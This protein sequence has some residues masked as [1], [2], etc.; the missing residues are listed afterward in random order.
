ME[1]RGDLKT[2]RLICPANLRGGK[3]KREVLGVG[4]PGGD[5]P[6][7]GNRGNDNRQAIAKIER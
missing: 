3:M 4:V 1:I 7:R 2:N 6:T 5:A